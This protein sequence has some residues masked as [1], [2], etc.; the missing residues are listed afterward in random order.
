M[1]PPALSS[2]KIVEIDRDEQ[3]LPYTRPVPSYN[4]KR[5]S[6]LIMKVRLPVM[7]D[8]K[9]KAK[10]VMPPVVKVSNV[11]DEALNWGDD[12]SCLSMTM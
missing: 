6:H 7:N 8:G 1:P 5:K 12:E 2:S 10:A 3:I 4:M 11:E 9:G